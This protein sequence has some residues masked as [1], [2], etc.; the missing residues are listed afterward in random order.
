M[1]QQ[2]TEL[3]KIRMALKS[4]AKEDLVLK[5]SLRI[6]ES[7][8]DDALLYFKV[9][10][11]IVN[12]MEESSMGAEYATILKEILE[13]HEN[14][15]E[16]MSSLLKL[17]KFKPSLAD[18]TIRM[19]KKLSNSLIAHAE[20]EDERFYPLA[21]RVLSKSQM[22]DLDVTAANI[23]SKAGREGLTGR[24]KKATYE[25]VKKLPTFERERREMGPLGF[26]PRITAM[27]TRCHNR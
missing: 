14:L 9:E 22:K 11:E 26:E 8:L 24:I 27:S 23:L 4:L 12:L 16:I 17:V 5:S 18:K 15:R 13:E 25:P 7:L 10:E 3:P 19:A 20:K 2:K 6:S 1:M 21:L